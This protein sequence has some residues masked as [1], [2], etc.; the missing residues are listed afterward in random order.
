MPPQDSASGTP[1]EVELRPNRLEVD[2]FLDDR[3]PASCL[4]WLAGW[5]DDHGSRAGAPGRRARQA[6]G[7]L[8]GRS[9]APSWPSRWA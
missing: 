4:L 2:R 6:C 9:G 3:A 5:A 7:V 8:D 1:G